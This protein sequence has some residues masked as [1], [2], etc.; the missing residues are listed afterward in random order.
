MASVRVRWFLHRANTELRRANRSRRRQLRQELGCYCSDA[1]RADLEAL[2]DN[3]PDGVTWEIR[4][5]L[6]DQAA[7]RDLQRRFA[8]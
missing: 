1:D 6:A 4:D 2:L 7:A 3:Y 5:I 8:R